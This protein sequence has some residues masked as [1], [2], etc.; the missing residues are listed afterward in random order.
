V[1]LSIET[2]PEVQQRVCADC[3][4]PFSSVHGFL[5]EDGNA[6]A[7]YHAMLQKDHPS[8]VV[9]L[10]V[11][12]GSWAEEATAA[13]RTRIGMRVWPEGDELKMHIND[14]GESA[15]GDS[16]TF[17]QIAGRGQVLGTPMEQEAL[18]TVEFVIAHDSRVE[19]HVRRPP[20]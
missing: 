8:A 5:Y 9:D 14:A 1:A 12:F 19:D 4:R 3:G 6:Y 2:T 7:V 15:R 11:S 18:R 20:G 10:A 13:D 16:D 17:G